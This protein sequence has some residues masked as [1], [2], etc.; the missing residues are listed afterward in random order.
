[1][2]EEIRLVLSDETILGSLAET[3]STDEALRSVG[4]DSL[5]AVRILIQIEEVFNVEFLD[6]H[7]TLETFSSIDSI[8]KAIIEIRNTA[9]L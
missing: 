6:H 8:I 7:L 4:V 9:D 2:E 1:M 3:I 5:L